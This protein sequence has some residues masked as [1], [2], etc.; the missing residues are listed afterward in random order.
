[1]TV[2]II[3]I[4]TIIIVI[5]IIVTPYKIKVSTMTAKVLTSCVSYGIP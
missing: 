1:M 2:K 4:L 5:L 3:V